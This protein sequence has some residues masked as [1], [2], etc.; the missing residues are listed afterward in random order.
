MDERPLADPE[1]ERVALS[2][3]RFERF[4]FH[5]TAEEFAARFG[6][7]FP[8]FNFDN[9]QYRTEGMTEWVDRLAAF[10]FAPDLPG[11]LRAAREK[12]LT[13]EE[14]AE[15]EAYERDPL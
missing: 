9:F 14:I 3:F 11:R 1:Y 7:E 6:H 4:R 8:L 12:Y 2:L 13:S 5:L 10:F 15:A